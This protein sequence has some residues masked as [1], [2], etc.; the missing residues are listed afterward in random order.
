MDVADVRA[1]E[2]TTVNGVR[3]LGAVTAGVVWRRD[4]T[5]VGAI[6]V[7]MGKRCQSWMS[8]S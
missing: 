1:K 2:L 7:E 5:L 6:C 4:T 3:M 8:I